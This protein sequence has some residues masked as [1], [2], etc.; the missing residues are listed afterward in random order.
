MK[1]VHAFFYDLFKSNVQ[2]KKKMKRKQIYV[3][4]C[5]DELFRV[6]FIKYKKKKKKVKARKKKKKEEKNGSFFFDF[7][8]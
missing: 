3:F 6:Y 8:D 4:N 7:F 1:V 2:K 5:G